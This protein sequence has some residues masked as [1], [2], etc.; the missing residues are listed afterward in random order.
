MHKSQPVP[1]PPMPESALWPADR[2]HPSSTLPRSVGCRV[3]S[4]PYG[5]KS[6]TCSPRHSHFNFNRRANF[7]PCIVT[8]NQGEVSQLAT[9]GS[10]WDQTLTLSASFPETT[11]STEDLCMQSLTTIKENTHCTLGM[12]SGISSSALMTS[13]GLNPRSISSTTYHSPPRL[14][15]T[16]KPPTSSSNIR[17]K[18]AKSKPA[19]GKL[20]NSRTLVHI[21]WKELTPCTGLKRCWKS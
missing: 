9:P 17:K 19:C 20:A 13:T 16:T 18:Y 3:S 14:G 8:D 15:A 7:V 5:S 2:L 21:G 4:L 11:L 6:T 10:S 12:T 1:C